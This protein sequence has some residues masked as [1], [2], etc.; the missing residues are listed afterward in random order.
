MNAQHNEN[1]FNQMKKHVQNYGQPDDR[2]AW[3]GIGNSIILIALSI[4]FIKVDFRLIGFGLLSL[5]TVR[6]FIQFHDMAH[7]SYFSSLPLNT[8]LG[9]I[10]GVYTNYPFNPWRDGHNHHHKHFGNLDRLDMSQTI[11]FTK[12]QYENMKGLKKIAV[13]ILR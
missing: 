7:F 10:I 8:F 2:K 1:D 4:M 13:R 5:T 11:L 3:I 6:L 12:K 9:K